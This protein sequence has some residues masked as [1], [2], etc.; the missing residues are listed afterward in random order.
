MGL[1][2]NK[3]KNQ[4]DNK[5]KETEFNLEKEKDSKAKL[6]KDK[7]KVEGDFKAAKEK[8]DT[9]E[10]E[11]SAGKDLIS[12]RDKSIK[13]LEEV[14]ENS[15]VL[16]KQLQKKIAELLAR[17]EELEEEL[18]NERKAKQKTELSRKELESNLEE[19]NEQLLV[20]GD[21]TTAQSEIAKKKDAEIARLKKEVEEAVASGEDAVSSLKNKHAALLQE[22][23]D[24]TEAVKKAKAKSDKD[25]AAVA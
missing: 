18:E 5:L 25:K 4:I 7:R 1:V 9:L 16:I 10:E 15:E 2:S 3:A 6:D 13:E 20:Q 12:K 19:L 8:I 11:V 24:E 21:A 17:V 14:K 23:Q 22:A